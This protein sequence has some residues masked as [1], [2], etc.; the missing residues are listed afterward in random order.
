M[1]WKDHVKSTYRKLLICGVLVAGASIFILWGWTPNDF[2]D[3]DCKLSY[4]GAWISVDWTSRPVSKS[5][6]QQLAADASRR[7]IHYLFPY[8]SYLKDDGTFS[9][10][11]D[12][13][14]EFVN[15]FREQDDN[16]QL[17]AWIG[18]PLYRE[19]SIGVDGWVDLSQPSTRRRVVDFI[20]NL[21][22]QAQFDGVHLNAETVQNN[23][24]DFLLLLGE[25]RAKLGTGKIISIAGSHWVTD[26]VNLLPF[27]HDF[28][29]TSAYYRM[30]G[31]QVDQIV[32][33]TYD[34]Y[35]PHAALYR[36]WMR[37][38]VKEI[39]K[40]VEGTGAE[41][42]VGVSVSRESTNSHQPA[43]ENL[44]SGLAGICAGISD[45]GVVQGI[46]VYADWEFSQSDWQVWQ[47]WQR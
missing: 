35:S 4:N 25:I 23:D 14:A 21:V 30:I 1:W 19:R 45:G 39:A 15:A 6:V 40:S 27:V 32:T 28:R 17:L 31:S 9:Q 16:I 41:L 11:Y 42:L 34:S 47:T 26:Y 37:E 3:P 33:M 12:Y 10:S 43:A 22:E 24:G 44:K 5:A 46:S 8:V 20:G 18:L 7:N 2:S 36:L 29:W 13:A 38:Q